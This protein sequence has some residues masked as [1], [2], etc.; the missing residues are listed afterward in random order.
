MVGQGESAD[1]D[2]LYGDLTVGQ[3]EYSSD[4]INWTSIV[5]TNYKNFYDTGTGGNE[6]SYEY[7]YEMEFNLVY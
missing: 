1:V 3:L 4:G 6:P 2:S 5:E 7:W